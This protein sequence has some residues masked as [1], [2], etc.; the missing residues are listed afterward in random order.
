MLSEAKH[1]TRKEKQNLYLACEV[2]H[3]VQ[4]DAG[5]PPVMLS[6]TKHRTRKEKTK[7]LPC[8]WGS[9]LRSE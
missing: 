4:N 6:K 2:L 1:R 3:C 9:S 7:P 8:L 5:Y